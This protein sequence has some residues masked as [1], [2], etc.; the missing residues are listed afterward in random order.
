[1]SVTKRIF[2][3]L[4]CV[5][6]LV[7]FIIMVLPSGVILMTS[8]KPEILV[9]TLD[10]RLPETEVVYEKPKVGTSWEYEWWCRFKEPM[11][12]LLKKQIENKCGIDGS[13]WVR[14]GDSQY[15]YVRGTYADRCL[16]CVVQTDGCQVIY[17]IDDYDALFFQPFLWVV[18]WGSWLGLMLVW[19]MIRV[20]FDKCS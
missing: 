7:A 8:K 14:L 16:E 11:S 3:V 10:V 19:W 6:M 12:E 4:S 20:I 18:I 2:G 17:Y 9:K 13:H 15:K 1:M 5:L